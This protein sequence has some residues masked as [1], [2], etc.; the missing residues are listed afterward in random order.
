M[1]VPPA[2]LPSPPDSKGIAM[3]ELPTMN[4]YDV[5]IVG[6]RCAGAAT[7]MLLAR[8][9]LDVLCFDRAPYGSDTLSTHALM[10]PAVM[11]LARWGLLPRLEAEGTPKVRRTVFDYDGA[12]V[13]VPIR[14]YGAVDALYAPR[15]TVLDR[16]LV[17]AARDAGAEVVHGLSMEGVL[18]GRGRRV[19]GVEVRDAAGRTHEIRARWVVGADGRRSPTAAAVGAEKYIVGR[20]AAPVL[21]AHVDGMT[22]DHYRWVYRPGIG[23]GAIPTN[24]GQACVF[25]SLTARRFDRI[26]RQDTRALFQ[27]MLDEVSPALGEAT[28]QGGIRKVRGYGGEPGYYR[29]A[30]GRGWALVGDSGYFKDPATAHGISDALVHAELL[31]RAIVTG[32]EYAVADYQAERDAITRPFFEVTERVAAMDWDMAAL[33]ACHQVMSLEMKREVKLITTFDEVQSAAA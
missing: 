2:A 24:D 32:N 4:E 6:A 8:A 26:V 1:R 3:D 21:Y 12:I 22:M 18:W 9:G 14:P 5:I 29:Q 25:A 10:R 33:Q 27:S 31:S 7:A 17:D 30:S 16:A 11:Q 15:R 19:V 23:A 13:D 20:H 28:R